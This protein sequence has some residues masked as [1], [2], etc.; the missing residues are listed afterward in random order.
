M[1]SSR[2][3]CFEH[4][5]C[6]WSL[7][8]KDGWDKVRAKSW[9]RGTLCKLATFRGVGTWQSQAVSGVLRGVG[10]EWIQSSQLE[11]GTLTTGLCCTCAK[12]TPRE[13]ISLHP[14]PQ[15]EA[16]VSCSWILLPA[17][18]EEAEVTFQLRKGP[19]ALGGEMENVALTPLLNEEATLLLSV[20]GSFDSLL[21]LNSYIMKKIGSL[22]VENFSKIYKNDRKNR[23]K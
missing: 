16:I 3:G 2:A 13:R 10:L 19:D 18:L 23:E 1:A 7:Q 5:L 11:E 21:R 20:V 9:P 17:P 22:K 12:R 8:D 6:F 14:L 15:L 4:S